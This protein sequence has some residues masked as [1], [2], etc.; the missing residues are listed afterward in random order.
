[1][2]AELVSLNVDV[3]MG[4]Q[5]ASPYLKNATTK[6]PIVFM[7]VADPVGLKLVD[8]LA[9][10]GGNATGLSSF[11]RDLAGKRLQF[12]KET[13]PRLSRV[14]LL[15]N[16]NERSARMFIDVFQSAAVELGLVIQTFEARSLEELEP[17]FDAMARAGMQAVTISSGGSSFRGEQLSRNWRLR[18]VCRSPRIREKLLRMVPLCPMDL[19]NRRCVAVRLSTSTRY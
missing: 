9:H 5:T 16:P 3:L 11:G 13:V 1:M 8:S 19:T 15:V 6:I 18:V 12:L 4:G 10:P 17:A 2:A 14:A 7:F